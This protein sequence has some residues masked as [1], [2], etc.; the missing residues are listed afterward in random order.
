MR[1]D[2]VQSSPLL[3]KTATDRDERGLLLL[4][5]CKKLLTQH[6]SA[7]AASQPIPLKIDQRWVSSEKPSTQLNR[8]R[9]VRSSLR[10]SAL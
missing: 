6:T 5:V 7:E 1:P 9:S 4:R 10:P 8:F 3:D 2:L